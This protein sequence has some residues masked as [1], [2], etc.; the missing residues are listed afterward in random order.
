MW[1]ST[2]VKVLETAKKALER[3]IQ[4]Q[5][6]PLQFTHAD[7]AAGKLTQFKQEKAREG[8][9]VI[10]DLLHESRS[11]NWSKEGIIADASLNNQLMTRLLIRAGCNEA[12]ISSWLEQYGTA[13]LDQMGGLFISMSA[14]VGNVLT[15]VYDP[16]I[17]DDDATI[18]NTTTPEPEAKDK[19]NFGIIV[20]LYQYNF[21]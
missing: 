15:A 4:E 13:L 10:F 14:P 7:V 18:S 3:I 20:P 8:L 12:N 2:H 17:D 1:D 5:K 11:K 21:G 19:H 6:N 16:R 9:Q